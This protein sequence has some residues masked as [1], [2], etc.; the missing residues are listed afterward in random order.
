MENTKILKKIC[1]ADWSKLPELS[2]D[3]LSEDM[4]DKRRELN[5]EDGLIE[6]P[7]AALDSMEILNMNH[8]KLKEFAKKSKAGLAEEPEYRCVYC[9][10]VYP[11]EKALKEHNKKRCVKEYR[12][13]K[14]NK[15]FSRK[16]DIDDHMKKKKSCVATVEDEHVC[17]LCGKSYTTDGILRSHIKSCKLKNEEIRGKAEKE[18]IKINELDNYMKE[19]NSRDN[20]NL[21]N[22][23]LS[24]SIMKDVRERFSIQDL[25]KIAGYLE[26]KY[27]E[28]L[29]KFVIKKMHYSDNYKK[30]Q[31]IRYIDELDKYIVY[32]KQWQNTSKE[33]ILRILYAE[34]KFAT[35]LAR[36]V[37]DTPGNKILMATLL[38]N[39]GLLDE[40]T[41]MRT[42]DNAIKNVQTKY[43]E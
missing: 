38:E 18:K 11:G 25:G 39:D 32:D 9:N 7:L 12:C 8:K 15:V 23:C 31:N 17:R 30:H 13:R 5:I 22:F 34:V 6:E 35:Y 27:F 36:D 2:E 3:E 1:L 42:Q 28:K 29:V 4:R 41:Y 10:F 40:Y 33:K 21:S 20:E 14:C 16:R 37:S 24:E 43:E 26:Y 19:Y